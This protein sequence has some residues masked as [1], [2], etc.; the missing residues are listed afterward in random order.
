MRNALTYGALGGGAL[1]AG[2][3]AIREQEDPGSIFLA[4]LGGG[5]GAI[6]GLGAARGLAGKFAPQ[7]VRGINRG[8]EGA[9]D[10][11]VRYTAPRSSV[12]TKE[13]VSR[14][15][16][17]QAK[18]IIKELEPTNLGY[19]NMRDVVDPQRSGL[20]RKLGTATAV[21][22]VPAIA[23]AGGFGG[24]TAGGVLG[25]AGLPGFVDPESYG[26]S[27]SPGARYKQTTVNYV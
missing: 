14:P 13:K 6:G 4:G 20:A 22:T 25:A 16:S 2:G 7:L 21:G 23:L 1:L 19:K 15:F 9:Q 24:A 27:N 26:S 8:A 11:L 18:K 17:H 5:A 12:E 10:A 3:Q